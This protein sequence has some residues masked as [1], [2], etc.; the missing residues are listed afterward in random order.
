MDHILTKDVECP[1]HQHR[2]SILLSARVYSSSCHSN[3]TRV[4]G[5]LL[6]VTTFP[7]TQSGNFKY[8][9][10]ENK[11]QH[12]SWL[13]G[14]QG[15]S[16]LSGKVYS[17]IAWA[18]KS[19]HFLSH[20]R[21]LLREIGNLHGSFQFARMGLSVRNLSPNNVSL[22]KQRLTVLAWM[23]LFGCMSTAFVWVRTTGLAVFMDC[24]SFVRIYERSL[25]FLFWYCVLDLS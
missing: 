14:L 16:F 12:A 1:W 4:V 15:K 3:T 22:W 20:G 23:A 6:P 8:H 7:G 5:Y 24:F 25:I 10:V 19:G 13:P 9:R 17:F 21:W 2:R 18:I 11:N